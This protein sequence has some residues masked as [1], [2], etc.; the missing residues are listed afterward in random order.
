MTYATMLWHWDDRTGGGNRKT[1]PAISMFVGATRE[2]SLKTCQGCPLLHKVKGAN[3]KCYSQCGV[4]ARSHSSITRGVKRNPTRYLW[5]TVKA[6]AA[7][8]IKRKD[9][10]AP[11]IVRL[12]RIGDP[13]GC[14][15]EELGQV[16]D[17]AESMGLTNIAYTHFWRKL[18]ESLKP[19][20]TASVSVLTDDKQIDEAGTMA[21]AVALLK[22]GARRVAVTLPYQWYQRFYEEG[23]FFTH[24]GHRVQLCPAQLAHM[25]GTRTTCAKCKLCDPTR[26]GPAIIAFVDHSPGVHTKIVSA[27]NRGEEWAHGLAEKL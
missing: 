24:E 10:R 9:D 26:K 4:E 15:P 25:K 14:D 12:S 21:E 5:E 22:E 3:A 18:H 6:K 7:P 27:S 1:G 16:M 17:E 19:R 11:K 8:Y 2:E 13:S 23:S 20:F